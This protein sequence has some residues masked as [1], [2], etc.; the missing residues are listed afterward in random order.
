VPA[1]DRRFHPG[2]GSV[3]AKDLPDVGALAH[4]SAGGPGTVEEDGVEAASGQPEGGAA[5]FGAG[6]IGGE[7]LAVGSV[8]AHRLHAA[9]AGADHLFK[10]AHLLE[11]AGTAGIDV[12]GAGLGAGK[13]G[14]VEQH[15]PAAICGQRGGRRAAGGAGADHDHLGIARVSH[16]RRSGRRRPPFGTRDAA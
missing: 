16:R 13:S 9:G 11:H 15:H 12:V 3:A 1:V 6:E 5:G 14:L 10:R 4:H 7:A 2:H 8:H